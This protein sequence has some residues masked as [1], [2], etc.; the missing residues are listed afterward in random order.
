MEDPHYAREMLL[1]ASGQAPGLRLQQLHAVLGLPPPPQHLHPHQHPQQQLLTHL[2]DAA[3]SQ[4]PAGPGR[5]GGPGPQGLGPR[6]DSMEE[7][8]M[9]ALLALNAS[10]PMVMQQ[11]A[12]AAAAAA[13][14]QHGEEQQQQV[15]LQQAGE[16]PQPLKQEAAHQQAQHQ[17][18][19]ID[20]WEAPPAQPAAS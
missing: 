7:D 10:A 8:V 15:P 9:G 14:Q 1:A 16:R 3:T 13:V 4:A 12:A 17:P 19:S 5:T 20:L 11:A 18:M 2:L 6:L